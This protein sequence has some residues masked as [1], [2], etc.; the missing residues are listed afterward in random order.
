[1]NFNLEVM[2]ETI[3]IVL[4]AVPR[5]FLMAF[6]ILLIGILFGGIIAFVKIKRIPILTQIMNVFISYVR[7]V[8]LIVHLFVV[9]SSLPDGV[10]SL[11]N[12]VGFQMEP[13]EFPSILIV[14]VT[15][16]FL[17]AAI[18][19]ENIRGA[20]QSIDP[21]QIEAGLSI[22]FTRR[23]NLRRV[24]VP[25]AMAVALP[26]FLNALLKIIKALSLAFTVGAVDIMAQA[27]FAAALSSRY[28]ESYVA[29][30]LVYWFICGILLIV[31]NKIEKRLQLGRTR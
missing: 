27:R 31:F 24:I 13:H 19:S 29:A 15:Y 23:Q 14:L 11:L 28:L 9:M 10:S 5:T 1:M 21:Q 3:L 25:Q 18:Q 17:E 12:F 2:F 7:G 4:Q 26:M 30:A 20:F 22:G 16:S 8:P 6:L